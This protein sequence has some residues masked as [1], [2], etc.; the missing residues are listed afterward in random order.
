MS[1]KINSWDELK[2]LRARIKDQ[3]E[4]D[5]GQTVVAVGVGTCGAAA[6]ANEIMQ[7]IQQEID[8]NGIKNA[9]V[10]PTGCYGFCYAEPMVE[11]RAGGQST[12]YKS[13]DEALAKAIVNE[14]I[15]NGKPITA[16]IITQ[17]VEK[18]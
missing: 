2:Q 11:I 5:K 9:K 10:V 17:E 18:V 13:V 12:M 6:G 3:A 15:A 8:K 16:S 14:H 4:V 1:D 7:T